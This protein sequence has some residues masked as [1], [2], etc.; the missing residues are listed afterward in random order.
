MSTSRGGEF[1]A[2]SEFGMFEVVHPEFREI[3]DAGE[4]A[5]VNGG[6]NFG[7]V[8][9]GDVNLAC[10]DQFCANSTCVQAGCGNNVGC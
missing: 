2:F 6:A 1:V 9:V 5:A 7:C 10:H 8:K 3:I 4:L